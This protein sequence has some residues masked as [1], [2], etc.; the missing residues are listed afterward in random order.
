MVNKDII[1]SV[2][3][4]K[5]G[6][7]NGTCFQISVSGQ[8]Y[9]VSAKHILNG[10]KNNDNIEFE[11]FHDNSWK[12]HEGKLLLHDN[13]N[14]DIAVIDLVEKSF[15]RETNIELTHSGEL[16]TSQECF[17]L[18]FPYNLYSDLPKANDNLP[19]PFIKKAIFSLFTG[20]ESNEKIMY[21]DGHNN[22]GFSGG[23][24]VAEI[25]GKNI[26]KICSVVS[27]YIMQSNKLENTTLLYGENSGIIVTYASV[28]IMEIINSNASTQQLR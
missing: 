3:R 28:H 24:V 16:F 17:F 9:L 5:Y 8:Q 21:L 15:Y 20:E 27:S 11:I 22:P 25:I 14:I 12:T 2:Y 26:T 23:P 10:K 6:N 7:D 18:G 1:Q 4:I 13:D 19:V